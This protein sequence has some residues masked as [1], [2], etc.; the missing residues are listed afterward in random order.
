MPKELWIPTVWIDELLPENR[1]K[2]KICS[3]IKV[4]NINFKPEE[5]CNLAYLEKEEIKRIPTV[6]D[7]QGNFIDIS[8]IP[9]GC[10]NEYI[11][12]KNLPLARRK[13]KE[14]NNN[15]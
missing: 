5:F 6:E 1:D 2:C 15:S 10:P 4:R 3:V 13:N 9:Q 12:L 7:A 11:C 14:Q 8:K